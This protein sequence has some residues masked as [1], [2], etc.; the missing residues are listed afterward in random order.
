MAGRLI[1]LRMLVKLSV[2]KFWL[3]TSNVMASSGANG[4]AE[5]AYSR[6]TEVVL[7]ERLCLKI[8]SECVVTTW[9]LLPKIS[10]LGDITA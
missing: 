2:V 1:I 10:Y 6:S 7:V 8:C 4:Q 3:P 9:L 5:V